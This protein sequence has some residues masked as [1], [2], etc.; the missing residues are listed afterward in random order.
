MVRIKIL[1]EN[2]SRDD[3]LTARHGLSMLIHTAQSRILL[4]TGPD[5]TFIRNA[6]LMNTELTSVEHLVLSHAHIDHTGGINAFAGINDDAQ[7][8]LAGDPGKRYY[9]K[10]GVFYIPVGL[11]G[12]NRVRK[13]IRNVEGTEKISSDAWMVECSKA[14][15]FTSSLN[16]NLYMKENGKKVCDDFRHESTLVIQDGRDLI[17]FNSCSH[18]GVSNIIESVK[19]AFPG[20]RIRS[21]VGGMHLC[22]SAGK[23]REKRASIEKLGMELSRYGISYYTGHCTG[24]APFQ[25]LKKILGDRIEAFSTGMEF[26]V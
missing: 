16:R 12:R 17:L 3:R 2:T 9:F 25:Q 20:Y 1:V 21:F 18:A 10:K 8:Y 13:R 26:D 22:S 15:G 23:K 5:D 19:E 24:E 14:D 4:D 7:I 11:K 6:D